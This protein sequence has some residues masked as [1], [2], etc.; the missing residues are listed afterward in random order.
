MQGEY[1]QIMDA[2]KCGDKDDAL[3]VFLQYY[4]RRKV[5]RYL[6]IAH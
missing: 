1:Q 2:L 6:F 5:G 4:F 3:E